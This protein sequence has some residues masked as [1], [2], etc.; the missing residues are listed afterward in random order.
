MPIVVGNLVCKYRLANGQPATGIVQVRPVNNY[1][2]NDIVVV[3]APVSFP[4]DELGDLDA[5][6]YIDNESVTP[7]LYLEIT[8]KIDGVY[9]P[10]PYIVKPEGETTNLATAQRYTIGGIVPTGDPS[11]GP[12]GPEGPEGPAG[13]AATISVGSTTTGV[14]GSSATVVNAGSTSAAVLNFTIPRGNA[15]IQ[16]VPGADG[17]DTNFLWVDVVTGS[18]IRPA[19]DKVLWIGGTTQ[20]IN[21]AI[22]DVWMQET[23]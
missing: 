13:A 10:K 15:G 22:G 16:G 1:D 6:V 14:A 5:T 20:P 4:I 12:P 18:E 2:D 8:E 19:I 9:R 3:P 17:Q 21:M 11:Q 7:D 23:V